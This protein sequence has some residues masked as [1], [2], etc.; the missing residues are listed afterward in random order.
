MRI[1]GSCYECY[2]PDTQILYPLV[3]LQDVLTLS[4]PNSL[5]KEC[6]DALREYCI[7]KILPEN[8]Y[9]FNRL[10]LRK[11][12]R[13]LDDVKSEALVA[14]RK[15]SSIKSFEKKV[16]SLITSKDYGDFYIYWKEHKSRFN[17]WLEI[18]KL[19]IEDEVN[20][21][22]AEM[23]V[24]YR[25]CTEGMRHKWALK[26][27]EVRSTLFEVLKKEREKGILSSKVHDEDL[28]LLVGCLLYVE[29]YLPEGVLYLVT[30]DRN[31]YDCAKKVPTLK[32]LVGG[33]KRRLVGF[34]VIKPKVF[35]NRLKAHTKKLHRKP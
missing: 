13:F 12:Q 15:R 11:F 8:N 21:T 31:F 6:I 24:R 28:R 1:F 9:E 2:V 26:D 16:G 34:D 22:V 17:K 30:N 5:Y 7:L 29:R 35:L 10:I 3:F 33:P 20:S 18:D 19:A 25:K 32:N 14:K 4:F 27:E 23:L